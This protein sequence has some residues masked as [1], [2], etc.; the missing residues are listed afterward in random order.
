MSPG[1]QVPAHGCLKVCGAM[2]VNEHTPAGCR[3]ACVSVGPIRVHSKSHTRQLQGQEA[4]PQC[5]NA[6][7]HTL[8][9]GQQ[10]PGCCQGG[11]SHHLQLKLKTLEDVKKNRVSGGKS[12]S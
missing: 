5:R 9:K 10:R 4:E 3:T 7:T 2:K 6:P 1:V 8:F 12:L 11:V